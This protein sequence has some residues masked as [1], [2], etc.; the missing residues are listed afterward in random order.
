MESSTSRC[1][2]PALPPRGTREER[3]TSQKMGEGAEGELQA[4]SF[5]FL[6]A[7]IINIR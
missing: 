7:H 2:G 5:G 3:L 4:P 1:F 6:T